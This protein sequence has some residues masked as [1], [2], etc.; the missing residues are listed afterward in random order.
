M[1]Y[2]PTQL[3]LIV[4]SVAGSEKIWAYDGTDSIATVAGAGYVTDATSKGLSVKDVV[5]VRGADAGQAAWMYVSA[6]SNGAATL[7]RNALLDGAVTTFTIGLAASS[8]TD[9]MD[10]TITAKDAAG[11]TVAGVH[12]FVM[13]MSEAATGAGLTGDT[14]SGDLTAGTGVIVGALTAKK[15][16]VLQTAATGIFVG[17]LVASTNP[18][19]QYV[20]VTIPATGRLVVSAAS[21]TNWEGA[22]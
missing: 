8:T 14:Y 13:H 3:K 17:T 9:G 18:T 19:D 4:Q 16:W 7:A 1:A 5:Y 2:D 15:A 6:I 11:A 21:G 20:A 10:I 12:N 22:T